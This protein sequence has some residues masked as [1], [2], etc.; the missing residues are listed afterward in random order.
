MISEIEGATGLVW[1]VLLLV[2]HGVW[3]TLTLKARHADASRLEALI[4]R[5]LTPGEAINQLIH[6]ILR[7]SM[8]LR[9]LSLAIALG[10]GWFAGSTVQRLVFHALGSSGDGPGG[11]GPAMIGF[12]LAL[13]LFVIIDLIVSMLLRSARSEAWQMRDNPT[14]QAF[15]A[16][17][18]RGVG[19][20]GDVQRELLSSLFHYNETKIGAVAIPLPR[21]AG[22]PASMKNRD[23]ASA[24]RHIGFSRFPVFDRDNE[25]VIGVVDFRE[26]I[27][28][29]EKNPHG[30]I[31]DHMHA[32]LIMKADVQVSA[33]IQKMCEN[34]A[35]L[36]VVIDEHGRTHGIVTLQDLLR[37]IVQDSR[38][39]AGDQPS[40]ARSWPHGIVEVDGNTMMTQLMEMLHADDEHVGVET[41]SS[42]VFNRLGRKPQVGDTLLV[43]EL[44]LDVLEVVGPSAT[45]IRARRAR[46]APPI[47]VMNQD[48]VKPRS[49]IIPMDD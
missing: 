1:A 3:S 8:A 20:F 2:A 40:P 25:R 10:F 14:V 33:A 24:V 13:A 31:T 35:Q 39:E 32:P 22:L 45:R 26:L 19:S 38:H 9:I 23:A 5:G 7:R 28:A 11:I 37:E 12:L 17:R 46:H 44:Q 6:N 16:L 4:D 15:H 49:F 30:S 27:D 41:V 36:A 42:Y 34:R 29:V 48:S 43:G 21:I 18:S 47:D